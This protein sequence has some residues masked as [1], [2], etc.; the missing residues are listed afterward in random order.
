MILAGMVFM[1]APQ[2]L[3]GHRTIK[4]VAD[5]DVK[6]VCIAGAFNGWNMT[7]SPLKAVGQIWTVDLRLPVGR[8]GYKLVLDGKDWILDPAN[9][10]KEDG[11]NVDFNSLI[12]IYPEGYEKPAKLGDGQ[13]TKNA[14]L[15][16]QTPANITIDRGQLVL[17]LRVRPGD[18]R[19][20]YAVVNGRSFPTKVASKDDLFEIRRA[21]IPLP[22]GHFSYYFRLTDGIMVVEYVGSRGVT[23][24]P[25]S[26]HFEMDRNRIPVVNVPMW[27]ERTV[28]YEIFPDRFANG[29]SKNDPPGTQPWDAKPDFNRF[30]G[31]DAAGVLARADYLKN[32]GI[33]GVYFTPV[34]ESPANH[35]YLTQDFLKIDPAFAAHKE[36]RAMTVELQKRGIRSV[37]DGVFSCTGT[38]FFAFK[39]LVKNQEKSAYKDWYSVNKYPVKVEGKPTY[40]SWGGYGGLPLVNL[41]NL[42]ARNYLLGV[43]PYWNKRASLS[44]WRL[45]SAERLT[46]EFDREFRR[47]EKAND[48]QGWIVGE[49]WGDANPWLQGDMF[50][51]VMG[52]QFRGA[53]VAFLAKRIIGP[54]QFM[55]RLMTT[56]ASYAPAVSRNLMNLLD[57]HDTPRFLTLC[58]GDQKTAI[59]GAAVLLTWPG[60]PC[61]Y[62]GEELGMEGNADPDNR[63][64]MRW[65]LVNN[66][67]PVLKAYRALILARKDNP[68]LQIGEPVPLVSDDAAGVVGYERVLDSQRA[69]V[70]VNR[71]EKAFTTLFPSRGRYRDVL[72]GT[73]FTFE[74]GARDL[75]VRAKT[76]LVML[77]E[78]S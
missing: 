30:M 36:F 77:R 13:I 3:M 11:G 45:D 20:V 1:S 38:D 7:T 64:G 17:S 26:P 52:Y 60:A 29:N 25:Q 56:Y 62:Y 48:P 55:G 5:H 78:K 14:I 22:R 47:L 69:F 41:K 27:P 9:P 18:I 33:G 59:L 32:L 54:T 16:R 63:R 37:L 76:A 73:I 67:N 75:T 34:F 23:S 40:E 12:T 6:S 57:S 42:S 10:N 72:T 65:D 4:Y 28:L 50:D 71:S 70:Y 66:H 46:P 49:I 31:G 39:D 74:V 21:R 35:R 15:H 51:S 58:G 43:A 19:D 53:A 2:M 61:I 24:N 44:G 8:Y 68:V